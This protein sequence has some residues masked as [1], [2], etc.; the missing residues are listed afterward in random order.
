MRVV[1]FLFIIFWTSICAEAQNSRYGYTNGSS[2]ILRDNHS[3][4]S[5][6]L[7]SLKKG[8]SLEILDEFYP[9]NNTN[10]AI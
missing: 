7:T 8:E 10:E 2:I 1:C 9:T 3:T 4:S 6:K 5:S